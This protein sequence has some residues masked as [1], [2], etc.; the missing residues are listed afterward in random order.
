MPRLA[1]D[2]TDEELRAGLSACLAVP[3]WVED[4][5]SRGPYGSL[6]DLLTVAREAATPLTAAEVDQ[7][8]ASHPRIGERPSGSGASHALSRAEQ[9]SSA[10]DDP[11]LAAA[12]AAGNEA[13][14]RRF[15]R[16]FLIRATGRTRPEILVELHRRLR[17]DPAAELE[18][19]AAELRDIALLRIRQ[20]FGVPDAITA[21]SSEAA[22]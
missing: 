1:L 20:V 22:G 16:V 12:L 5:A 6:A 10:S 9:R 21:P 2:L 14:E 15:G 7:A 4:V 11:A 13:Y 3:R 19:V 18:V 8:L 17:L